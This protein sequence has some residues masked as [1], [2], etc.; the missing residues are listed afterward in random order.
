M[1]L[2]ARGEALKATGRVTERSK[3]TIGEAGLAI[4]DILRC[5]GNARD[6]IELRW[7]AVRGEDVSGDG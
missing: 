6:T 4:S 5:I 7:C 2:G 1:G 3:D